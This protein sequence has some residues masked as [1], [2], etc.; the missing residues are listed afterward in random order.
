M[1]STVVF[2]SSRRR[3]TR[4][5]LV[6]GV[7]TC[8]LPIFLG[9]RLRERAAE[10]REVLAEHEEQPPVDGA[11]A[12]HHAVAGDFL[13]LHAEV[14][15]AVLDIHVPLLEGATVE[16]AL[17]ALPPGQLVLCVPRLAALSSAPHPP[18]DW[19]SRVEGKR[20]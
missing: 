4:G 3:H 14:E 19:E 5:A 20:V 12:S 11:V 10:H 6:T 17:Q 9:V 16:Q 18:A 15:A 8:A 13:L 2:L 7:Q 1:H